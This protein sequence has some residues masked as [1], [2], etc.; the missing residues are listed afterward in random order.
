[1]EA[2]NIRQRP[3]RF[4]IRMAA[5]HEEFGFA[6]EGGVYVVDRHALLFRYA[7]AD[8]K[9]L[10]FQDPAANVPAPYPVKKSTGLLFQTMPYGSCSRKNGECRLENA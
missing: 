7:A 8:R 5:V 6:R 2:T 4:R 3:R 1:M 10:V 9:Q